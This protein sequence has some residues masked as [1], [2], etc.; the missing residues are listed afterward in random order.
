[1]TKRKCV[2]EER[3]EKRQP[4]IDDDDDEKKM[5]DFYSLVRS[6]RD[7]RQKMAIASVNANWE[8]M[9]K[10]EGIWIPEFKWEDFAHHHNDVR[11]STR[12]FKE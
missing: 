2:E 6:I 1:M 4:A 8:E 7:A 3:R 9:G 12:A 5:N 10:G 11:A